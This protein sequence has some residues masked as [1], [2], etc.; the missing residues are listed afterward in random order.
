MALETASWLVSLLI[1]YT[2]AG[3][4]FAVA[5]VWRGVARVDPQAGRSTRGFRVMIFPGCVALWP[6]LLLRWL[7]GGPPRP[8]RT[9]HRRAAGSRT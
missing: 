1:V 4:V 2:I 6:L 5:F 3:L 8:E 9:A 7:R